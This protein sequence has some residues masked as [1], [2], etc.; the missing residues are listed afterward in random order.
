MCDKIRQLQALT[1]KHFTINRL[2]PV[3]QSLK[4]LRY[5]NAIL[6]DE[7]RLYRVRRLKSASP[8]SI[9]RRAV[10]NFPNNPKDPLNIRR[11]R[12]LKSVK[13]STRTTENCGNNCCDKS[14]VRCPPSSSSSS[15]TRLGVATVA[16]TKSAF[17]FRLLCATFMSIAMDK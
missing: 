17:S 3:K 5:I 6:G 10:Q 9:E 16:S 4:S 8:I 12:T 14:S 1:I 2:S 15:V 13:I 11:K 7:N